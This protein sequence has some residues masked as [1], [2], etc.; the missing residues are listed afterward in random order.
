MDV[1]EELRQNDPDTTRISIPHVLLAIKN[2]FSL[3]SVKVVRHH[4]PYLFES[5]EGKE[6]LAFYANRNESLHW[7]W[8]KELDPIFVSRVPFGTWEGLC[9]FGRR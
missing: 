6:T 9:E 2:N 1:I 3:R 5:A 8:R 4:R 7:V